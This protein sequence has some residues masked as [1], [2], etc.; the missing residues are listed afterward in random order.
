MRRT[1]SC[2]HVLSN[3]RRR[4]QMLL[5]WQ[6]GRS[7]VRS[8]NRVRVELPRWRTRRLFRMR[9]PTV[10]LKQLLLSS[11]LEIISRNYSVAWW[12]RPRACYGVTEFSGLFQIYGIDSLFAL[13]LNLNSKLLVLWLY[14]QKI[15]MVVQFFSVKHIVPFPTTR[16]RPVHQ[17]THKPSAKSL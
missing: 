9:A 17:V 8:L 3:D 10:K 11:K 16:W 12:V 15:L 5:R 1:K 6:S 4:R 2:W 13:Y 7:K 14:V